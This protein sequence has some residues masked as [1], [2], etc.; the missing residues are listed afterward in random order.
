MRF[1]SMD[2][3]LR[4]TAIVWGDIVDGK[5]IPQDYKIS[6]TSKDDSKKI[7]VSSDTISRV[8]K[9]LSLIAEI[10]AEV[11]PTICFAES[12]SGSKSSSAMM[13]YGV[14]CCFIAAMTPPAIEVTPTELK[15]GSVGTKTASKT[16]MIEWAVNTYP[17][18]PFE[19]KPSGEVVVGRME[20]VADAIA[21]AAAGIKTPLFKQIEKYA[22]I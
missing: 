18:F 22:T 10:I 9:T 16:E 11:K 5:V 15:M 13:S 14:S 19:K 21:C 3:S 17:D 4:N 20:H 1:I 6:I 12:P 7:R 2:P 8:R